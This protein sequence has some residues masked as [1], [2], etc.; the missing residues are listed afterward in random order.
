MS[1]PTSIL[2]FPSAIIHAE[3]SDAPRRNGAGPE[4]V[5][6][7]GRGPS[8]TGDPLPPAPEDRIFVH[9]PSQPER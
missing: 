5:S 2:L 7:A 6:L 1:H 4:R 9:R 8:E 3:T